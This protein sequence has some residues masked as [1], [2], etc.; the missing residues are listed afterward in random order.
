[1]GGHSKSRKSDGGSSEFSDAESHYSS[2]LDEV[3]RGDLKDIK[4]HQY[5][6]AQPYVKPTKIVSA[7]RKAWLCCTNVSTFWIPSFCL[8]RCGGM[9][10]KDRQT[11][12]REKVALCITIALM[13]FA[14]LFFIIGTGYL[15]CKKQEQLSP[16]ELSNFKQPRNGKVYMNGWYYDVSSIMDSHL[17]QGRP[18]SDPA[19]WEAKVLGLDVSS[20]FSKQPYWNLYCP[21]FPPT[22]NFSLFPEGNQGL[23]DTL[24][25]PHSKPGSP[26]LLQDPLFNYKK[27][28]VVWDAAT[29][30]NFIGD[31][32]SGKRILQAYDRIYDISAFYHP[33]QSKSPNFMGP[34]IQTI[35][36]SARSGDQTAALNALKIQTQVNGRVH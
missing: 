14:I 16:G 19:Y 29:V 20:M 26:N 13:N 25:Y 18:F 33:S 27:G 21:S 22:A 9:Y 32:A 10:A 36:D 8:S 5:L 4:K 28:S 31:A 23:Q 12:W 7:S 2:E 3:E 30:A 6:P 11:A 1:V 34:E 35:F 24:W 15:L 17:V